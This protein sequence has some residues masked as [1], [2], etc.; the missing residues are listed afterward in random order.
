MWDSS[1]FMN[2]EVNDSNHLQS[3]WVYGIQG[4]HTLRVVFPMKRDPLSPIPAESCFANCDTP[5][6]SIMMWETHWH[7]PSWFIDVYSTYENGYF[8]WVYHHI[9]PLDDWKGQNSHPIHRACTPSIFLLRWRHSV[10][11]KSIKLLK[12]MEDTPCQFPSFNWK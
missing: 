11:A 7:K 2:H 5:W 12:Q 9:C 10:G 6:Y 3:C 1:N 4:L 8:F